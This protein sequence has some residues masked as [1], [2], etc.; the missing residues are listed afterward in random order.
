MKA[1]DFHRPLPT[2]NDSYPGKRGLDWL[3]SDERKAIDR[4]LAL[5]NLSWAFFAVRVFAWAVKISDRDLSPYYDVA[6]I[7]PEDFPKVPEGGVWKIRTMKPVEPTVLARAVRDAGVES[8]AQ[9]KRTGNDPRIT[10]LGAFMRRASIDE[11]PQLSSVVKGHMS[12][13]GPRLFVR[14]EHAVL[15]ERNA[16]LVN[17]MYS[18]YRQGVKPGIAGAYSWLGR[19]QVP[20]RTRVSA[21]IVMC[22]EATLETDAIYLL[23]AISSWLT[24]RGAY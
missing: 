14:D 6:T 10:T 13:V 3:T 17:D 16:L 24:F 20:L 12:L 15:V 8:T 2:S 18:F 23:D 11:L 19:G 7:L 4:A 9:L 22:E 1:E 21:E 5:V